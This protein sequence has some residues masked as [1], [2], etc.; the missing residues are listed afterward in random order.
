MIYC[1]APVTMSPRPYERS[2]IA[3]G[4]QNVNISV[5]RDATTISRIEKMALVSVDGG[6]VPTETHPY[7]LALSHHSTRRSHLLRFGRMIIPPR[8][9]SHLECLVVEK[10]YGILPGVVRYGEAFGLLTS[11]GVNC[12]YPGLL[13]CDNL[14]LAQE[15]NAYLNLKYLLSGKSDAPIQKRYQ[16][17]KR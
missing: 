4:T 17:F 8:D 5:Q 11:M 9:M 13:I 15:T 6:T 3:R 7:F 2:R 16:V 12:D 1:L 14:T 10:V